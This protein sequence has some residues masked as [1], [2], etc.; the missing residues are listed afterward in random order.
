MCEPVETAQSLGDDTPVVIARPKWAREHGLRTDVW[1][2]MSAGLL[3][4][5][6][7][8]CSSKDAGRSER[9][10]PDPLC[11]CTGRNKEHDKSY[12]WR[13]FSE[14]HGHNKMVEAVN[15]SRAQSDGDPNDQSFVS[16]FDAHPV[17][18]RT[19]DRIRTWAKMKVRPRPLVKNDWHPKIMN[20]SFD[21]PDILKFE[22]EFLR[23]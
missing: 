16:F 9:E 23:L 21:K 7:D 22:K 2:H 19:C 6:I 11:K 8:R 18:V 3:A 1:S 5:P 13:L 4:W 14:F 12:R 10:A 20:P 17:F 15:S